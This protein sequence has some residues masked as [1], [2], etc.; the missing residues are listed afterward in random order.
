M[1]SPRRENRDSHG[2]QHLMVALRWMGGQKY[3]RSIQRCWRYDSVVSW[4][5]QIVHVTWSVVV[6]S[7]SRVQW[8][9]VTSTE[10]WEVYGT[11]TKTLIG[12]NNM[13]VTTARVISED[14][15]AQ[16]QFGVGWWKQSLGNFFLKEKER[17]GGNCIILWS[18]NSIHLRTSQDIP[19]IG[20]PCTR[21][22]TQE[23]CHCVSSF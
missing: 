12:A 17:V 2:I 18:C 20:F 13:Q 22:Y 19:N 5:L 7:L 10:C 21:S 16:T 11:R 8:Q 9:V 14:Q 6:Q 1:R 15:C 3:L 23:T 4:N